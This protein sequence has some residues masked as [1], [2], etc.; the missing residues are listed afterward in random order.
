VSRRFDGFALFTDAYVSRGA[1]LHWLSVGNQH[2]TLNEGDGIAPAHDDLVRTETRVTVPFGVA[3]DVG[4]ARDVRRD[5]L[6]S[7][8]P[9][10]VVAHGAPSRDTTDV[11]RANGGA[12]FTVG[13]ALR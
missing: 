9:W 8:L 10:W 6:L 13:L 12:I 4:Q 11:Y 3:L 7:I 2:D 5:L 1:E